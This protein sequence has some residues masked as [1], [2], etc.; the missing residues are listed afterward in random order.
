MCVDVKNRIVTCE[1]L[2]FGVNKGYKLISAIIRKTILSALHGFLINENILFIS[3]V[4]AL[5]LTAYSIDW[6]IFGHFLP[7]LAQIF[8]EI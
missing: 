6:Q 1:N 5:L 2:C 3:V 7:P 4:I 8:N